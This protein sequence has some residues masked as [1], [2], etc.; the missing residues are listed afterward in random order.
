MPSASETT[1]VPSP[2]EVVAIDSFSAS[3]SEARSKF[4]EA[5]EAAGA[6]L[7]SYGRNDL[8]GKEGEYLACD[9]AVLGND[10]AS[11]AA[12]VVA[13]THGSE[14]YC[15]SAILHR[16]LGNRSRSG[17]PAG[18][19]VVLVHAINPW[20]FSH[21]TRTTENNVDLNRN[22]HL[23]DGRFG[24]V[25]PSYDRLAPFYHG[26]AGSA[27]EHLD[28]YSA[29]RGYLDKNGWHIENEMWEG[30][31]NW[32]DGICY[33]GTKPEWSNV[34]FRRI[35]NDHLASVSQIGFIDWH[36][37]IGQYGEF[38]SII[39]DDPGSEEFNAA[40]GWWQLSHGGEG[41][42]RIGA[43]PKYQGLLC[44]SIRQEL[45][46]PKI[47]GAVIEFGTADEY[48][49]FRADRLDRWLRFEGRNDPDHDRM[50]ADYLNV[51]CPNDIAWRRFV[52]AKGPDLIDQMVSGVLA[53]R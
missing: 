49:A 52:L 40:I 13:G 6:R 10:D 8:A 39:F 46:S 1:I 21:K 5:S 4:L 26:S 37:M 14:G 11:S 27:S 35:V 30:Q 41:A 24:R 53:W 45:P 22:F 42:F 28:A 50:R 48:T 38:V 17:T 23:A 32:P 18:I 33:T 51:C 3:F 25:N 12:L 20:A 16:W 44:R 19:K 47:A 29:Y 15:G 2:S 31:G 7:F 9:V 34:T 36:T 43:A